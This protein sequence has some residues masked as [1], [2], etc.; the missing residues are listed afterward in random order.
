M[1]LAPLPSAPVSGRFWCKHP[2]CADKFCFPDYPSSMSIQFKF[3]KFPRNSAYQP[4]RGEK[5]SFWT[6]FA[7]NL[8]RRSRWPMK[9]PI[10]QLTRPAA[11]LG[12][13]ESE[14]PHSRTNTDQARE[15]SEE[16][17]AY[18]ERRFWGLG[19]SSL[20][21]SRLTLLERLWSQWHVT[22]AD[23]WLWQSSCDT[24][25]II[26]SRSSD[27]SANMLALVY[28]WDVSCAF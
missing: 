15:R 11:Q 2:T 22:T 17:R 12:L 21:M 4:C 24:M 16:V 23:Y 19:C 14:V 1:S 9:Q 20:H 3:Q 18:P 13:P 8:I 6:S 25:S 27:S 7:V 5:S 28:W 26:Y 10:D